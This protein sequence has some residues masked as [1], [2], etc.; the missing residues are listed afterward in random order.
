[1]AII[2]G[3]SRRTFLRVG[4]GVAGVGLLSACAPAAPA[5]KPAETKP[6]APAATTAPAATAAP[7]ARREACRGCQAG[8]AAPLPLLRPPRRSR[9]RPPSRAAGKPESQ[10][11]RPAHRQDRGAGDPEGGEAPG[12][13]RRGADAGRAGQGRQAAARR[14]A[15]PRGA[16]GH[17]ADARDRQ[18]RR[19]LAARLHRPGR[20]RELQPDHGARTSRST[21]TTP[22]TRSCRPSSRAGSCVDGG[23]T[24]RLSLRKGMKWSDG[25]AV[26]GRRRRSSGSRTSTRTRRSSPVGTRR[27]VDQRQAR[28]SS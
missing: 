7:A 25:A 19:H 3:L 10:A 12:Q 24:I 6:A 2:G 27:D 16:D 23:K 20:H 28:H 13:A 26:H 14:A 21:S 11:R 17:Q 22:A 15:R 18:V 9:P 4:L 1:M 5:A 8:R